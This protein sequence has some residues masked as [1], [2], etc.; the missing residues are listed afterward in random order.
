MVTKQMKHCSEGHLLVQ[1]TSTRMCLPIQ[2]PLT[3]NNNSFVNYPR[4]K[5]PILYEGLLMLKYLKKEKKNIPV[6]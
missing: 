6:A 2:L 4:K 3:S 1:M 5:S